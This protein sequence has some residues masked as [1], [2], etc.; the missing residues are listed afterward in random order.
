MRYRPNGTGGQ[1]YASGLRN[2]VGLAWQPGTDRLWS[3]DNGQEFLGDNIPP[4]EVDLI[5]QGGNYGWPYC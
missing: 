2:A 5:Q 3:D 1:V 4:D